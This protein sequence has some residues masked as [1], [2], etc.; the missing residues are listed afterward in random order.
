M[1]AQPSPPT[2]TWGVGVV[3]ATIPRMNRLIVNHEEISL[4]QPWK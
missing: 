3:I 2:A 1:L 4:W